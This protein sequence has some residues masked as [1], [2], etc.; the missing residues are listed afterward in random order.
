[1]SE[2]EVRERPGVEPGQLVMPF[3]LICDVSYSM[4][5]DM[6]ALNDGVERLRKAIVAEPLVDDV[7]QI[8]VMTF[9]D[10]A[11]VVMPMSQ[12]SHQSSVPKLGVEGGTQYGAAFRGLASAITSDSA[13]L[14]AQGYK[15]YRP[16][17]F[18]LTDGEPNDHNWHQTYT[19]TLTYNEQSGTGL[20][21]HPIFVPFGFRD[22]SETI[23]AQLAYPKGR[24]KYYHVKNKSVEEALQGI[25]DIIM[26]TVVTAGH[27]AG[28]GQPAVVQTAPPPGSGITQG[29]SAYDPDFIT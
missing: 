4:T 10:T 14:K 2:Y 7:A 12:M 21:A 3:Y 20:K 28:S 13:N 5:G 11:K 15:V 17:A 29:E 16:C 1:M 19:D 22:A 8:C 25:L 6:H 23:L 18:F 27:T 26:N 9:S 24:G